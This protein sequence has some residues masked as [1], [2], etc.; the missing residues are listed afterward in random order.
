MLEGVREVL[1]ERSRGSTRWKFRDRVKF[2]WEQ[3]QMDQYAVR[4]DRQVA[5]LSLHLQALHLPDSSARRESLRS[6]EGRAIIR[7]GLSAASSIAESLH[8]GSATSLMHSTQPLLDHIHKPF[9]LGALTAENLVVVEQE[10]SESPESERAG[11][12]EVDEATIQ[13]AKKKDKGKQPKVTLGSI[14]PVRKM[15]LSQDTT[16]TRSTL[17]KIRTVIADSAAGESS[18]K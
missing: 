9:A 14:P 2:L 4:L 12:N 16:D 13:H 1:V 8:S 11:P 5:A 7:N 6:P 3:V 18:K 17:D 15:Q 10:D